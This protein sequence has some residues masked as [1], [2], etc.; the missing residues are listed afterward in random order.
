MDIM[1]KALEQHTWLS[2]LFIL[3]TGAGT[4]FGAHVAMQSW[5]QDDICAPGECVK[6]STLER[7]FVDKAAYT[8][9]LQQEKDSSAQLRSAGQTISAQSVTIDALRGQIG[10]SQDRAEIKKTACAN[11]LDQIKDLDSERVHMERGSPYGGSLMVDSGD[12]KSESDT[13]KRRFSQLQESLT[14]LREGY[15]A[16]ASN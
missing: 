4:G 10:S 12:D 7:D 13:T 16:C 11:I 2:V 3:A 6:K 5:L 8:Q 9:L 14:K 1:K 15:A